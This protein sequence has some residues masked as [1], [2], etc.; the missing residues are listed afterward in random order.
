MGTLQAN[1]PLFASG[2]A[3][4]VLD[5][6]IPHIARLS[7]VDPLSFRITT[8]AYAEKRAAKRRKKLITVLDRIRR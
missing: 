4:Q 6:E 3:M 5:I 7:E 8:F 1:G 2:G